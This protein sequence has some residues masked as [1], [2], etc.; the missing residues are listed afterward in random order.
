MLL[1]S[2]VVL[3]D[4][5]PATYVHGNWGDVNEGDSHPS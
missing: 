3:P 5:I 4:S 1:V 2:H